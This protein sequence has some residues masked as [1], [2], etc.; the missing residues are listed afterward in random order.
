MK[1]LDAS[2]I[3]RAGALIPCTNAMI[4]IE[5]NRVLP[6]HYQLHVARLRMGPISEEGWR[7]Q[8][9]DID[10]QA[11]LLGS[12]KVEFVVLAQTNASF[13]APGYDAA[14]TRRI[15]A[16]CGAPA[17]TSGRLTA[18]AVKSLGARRIAFIS[19]YSDELNERG[20]AYYKAEHG[21]DVVAVETFGQPPTADAVNDMKPAVAE[22]AMQRADSPAVEAFIVAGGA[23]PTLQLIAQ[24]EKRF[25]KPV[26]TTN[27]AAMWAIFNAL[28]RGESLPGHGRLLEG[29]QTWRAGL[30]FR[31]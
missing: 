5:F 7:M 28:G 3:R 1:M 14:V 12:V 10:Y 26:V 23:L 4:E 27:Q 16:A 20:R 9:A 18:E 29:A 8:D 24:W 19:P 2:R 6:K 13:F 15:T 17:S 21:L 22:A 11:R 30:E 31:A 25:G